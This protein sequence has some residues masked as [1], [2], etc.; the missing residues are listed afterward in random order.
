MQRAEVDA[1]LVQGVD[2]IGQLGQ[3]LIEL[4]ASV[5]IQLI[6]RT[7]W[8]RSIETGTDRLGA[9]EPHAFADSGGVNAAFG[10]PLGIA[11]EAL[12]GGAQAGKPES[13][14]W[15]E[16]LQQLAVRLAQDLGAAPVLFQYLALGEPQL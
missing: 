4:L 14:A 13:S 3:Q 9:V 2:E 6:Q 15:A 11:C 1:A 7:A 12:R 10:E 5:A 16:D 8:Q